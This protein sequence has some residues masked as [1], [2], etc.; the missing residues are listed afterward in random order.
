MGTMATYG[1]YGTYGYGNSGAKGSRSFIY[2]KYFQEYF[3][4]SSAAVDKISIGIARRAVP[5]QQLNLLSSI[6]CERVN[7][8]YLQIRVKPLSHRIRRRNASI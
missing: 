5:L 3:S 2:C 4:F 1:Y 7:A 6:G 8:A